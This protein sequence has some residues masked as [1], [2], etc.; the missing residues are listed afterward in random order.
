MSS[1][2]A[3]PAT[4]DCKAATVYDILQEFNLPIGLLPDCAVDCKLDRGKGKL[5]VHLKG[6]CHFSLQEPYE[7]KYKSTVSGH[8]SGNK[9]TNLKGVSVKFMFFWVNIVEVVRNGDDLQFSVGMTTAS[10]PVDIFTVCPRGGCGVD[11]KD[12]KLR[13]IKAKSLVSSA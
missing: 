2:V 1:T 3:L 6:S 10:F 4:S 12:G 8:I 7:L 11:C 9:L 5:E 13:K